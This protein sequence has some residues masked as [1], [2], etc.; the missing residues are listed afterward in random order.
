VDVA[1]I[2]EAFGLGVPTG[3]PSYVARGELRR[4]SRLATTAGM[5]AIKE[6][7]LFVPAVD[8]ADAN[9]ELQESMLDAGVNL[10]RPRRTVDGHGLLGNVRVYEW[11]DLTPLPVGATAAEELLAA[12]LARMHVHAPSTD[13]AP[14]PWYCETMS[15]E[16]WEARVDEGAGMWWA[17][18]VAGL[19]AE[20]AELPRPEHSPAH[21]CHLDVC[22]ENV[23]LCDGRL[24]VIDWENAG[25]AATIQDLGSTL[26]DFFQG[27]VGRTKVFVDHYQRHGGPIERLEVAVFDM[28]R[29]VQANLIDFH[30]RRALDPAATPETHERAEQGLHACLA[31]PLTRQ[32]ADALVAAS[33]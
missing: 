17:P 15:R 9:I 20:L 33:S 32:L 26:W 10:P 14:D 16:E 28:A 18:V 4:V 29:V 22:P 8:E 1:D 31:R 13:Q 23:F 27:D 21:I 3:P 2:C 12:S 24:T 25:P 6:I 19:V 5:W 30:S 11:L 7:E